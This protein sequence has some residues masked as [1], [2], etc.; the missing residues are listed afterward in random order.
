MHYISYNIR[1]DKHCVVKMLYKC[2]VLQ[3]CGHQACT[4]VRCIHETNV[5]KISIIIIINQL[6]LVGPG[7]KVNVALTGS[8]RVERNTVR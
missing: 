6:P 3:C 2:Y 8:I 4:Y 7:Y 1:L 5:N